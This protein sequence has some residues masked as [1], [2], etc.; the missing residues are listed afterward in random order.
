MLSIGDK[1][2]CRHRLHHRI[3]AKQTLPFSLFPLLS[4]LKILPGGKKVI[5]YNRIR[6]TCCTVWTVVWYWLSVVFEV[7]ISLGFSILNFQFLKPAKA[8]WQVFVLQVSILRLSGKGKVFN[9]RE[10]FLSAALRNGMNVRR[11]S[12]SYLF[13]CIYH[14]ILG[15]GTA[16]FCLFT[17]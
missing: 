6:C 15:Y 1:Y 13:W 14:Y 17:I 10:R 8:P 2:K 5:V 7:R 4:S 12:E 11:G 9:D 16:T 3:E